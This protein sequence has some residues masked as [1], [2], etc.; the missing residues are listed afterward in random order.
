MRGARWSGSTSPRPSSRRPGQD[1]GGGGAVPR[2]AGNAEELPVPRRELRPGLLR[3]RGD[4]IRRSVPHRPGGGA[5]PAAGRPVRVQRDHAVDLGRLGRR[6]D[7][8]AT[9]EMRPTTSAFDEPST[10]SRTVPTITYQLTVRRLD[11]PLPRERPRGRRPD[12]APAAGGR[13]HDVRRLRAA[14][15]GAR[16]P[17]R[18]HLEGAEGAG[19][20]RSPQP[21][22][23]ISRL[24]SRRRCCGRAAPVPA[25]DPDQ[26]AGRPH[27]RPVVRHAGSDPP[28]MPWLQSQFHDPNG[29]WLWFPHAFI[30]TPLCCPS[31]ATI[32]TGRYDTQ[33]ASAITHRARTSTTRTRCRCGC[34]AAATRRVSSASTSTSTLGAA[35]RS[36]RPAGI[37]GS[38]SRTRPSPRRT[39]TT[40]SSTRACAPLRRRARGLRHRRARGAGAPVPPGRARRCA[41]VPLLQPERAA[42]AVGPGPGA[43][44][45]VRRRGA[46]DPGSADDERRAR[47]ARVRAGARA[48]DRGGPTGL[49]PGRSQRARDAAVGRRLV[50]FDRRRDRVARRTRQHGDRLHGRQRVRLRV[51]PA[52]RQ[53]V[54]LHALGG[55]AVRDPDAVGA[56]HDDRRPGVERRRHGDDRRARRRPT[57]PAADGGRPGAGDPRPAAPAPPGRLPRL[58]R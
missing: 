53:A 24:S 26:R 31:R 18:T 29:H 20:R 2:R 3:S 17:R 8:P 21:A 40:G 36:S 58:G 16:V 23:A 43:C 57:G 10:P 11:P 27:R 42:S 13:R 35:H 28:A 30:Q 41:V 51:P 1:G 19:C 38:P 25:P 39:T 7:Q 22:A 46:S 47:Q 32:L 4:G 12:R 44:R 33:P 56:G 52:R 50:P 54:P 9:R 15:V 34:T 45:R 5:R 49:H 6:E 55:R 14:R 37:A 48:Q